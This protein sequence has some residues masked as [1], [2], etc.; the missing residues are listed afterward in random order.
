MQYDLL[1]IL[2]DIIVAWRIKVIVY[3]P[4]ETVWFL[5]SLMSTHEYN[6]IKNDIG[7]R[8]LTSE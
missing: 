1:Y 8:S 3:Y 4:I 2:R 7:G 6:I 5:A